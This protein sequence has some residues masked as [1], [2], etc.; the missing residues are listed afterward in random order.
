MQRHAAAWLLLRSAP[1]AWLTDQQFQG[2]NSMSH[3]KRGLCAAFAVVTLGTMQ[4]AAADLIDSYQP[5]VTTNGSTHTDI[6][7]GGDVSH[8]FAYD[9]STIDMS[10][11]EVSRLTLNDSAALT[12]SGGDVSFLTLNGSASATVSGGD[13]SWLQV[14]DNS[15]ASITGQL[16][17]LWLVVSETSHVDLFVAEATFSNGLFS[18]TWRDGSLFQFGTLI[19]SAGTPGTSPSALPS[20]ITIHSW[21]SS[22]SVPE[23]STLMLLACG[24]LGVGVT[25]GSRIRG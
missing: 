18:G 25:R 9:A 16:N 19:G 22:A 20:N 21:D 5:Y 3:L 8:L 17:L 13:V 4:V 10:D 15:T 7:T 12:L 14:Y 23:P 24:L 1:I 2:G 11:G 6:V